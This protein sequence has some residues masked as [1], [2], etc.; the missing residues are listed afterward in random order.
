MRNRMPAVA[1]PHQATDG[2][3]TAM[4][5]DG[6]NLSKSIVMLPAP[7]DVRRPREFQSH[8]LSAMHPDTMA[9]LKMLILHLQ[10]A[11]QQFQIVITLPELGRM[12]NQVEVNKFL[13]I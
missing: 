5:D 11:I 4:D 3:P 2:L 6:L 10:L 7:S 9:R 1:Q 13:M 12:Q 8:V